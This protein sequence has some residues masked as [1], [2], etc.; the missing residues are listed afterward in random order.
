MATGHAMLPAGVADVLKAALDACDALGDHDALQPHMQSFVA[1][2]DQLLRIASRKKPKLPDRRTYLNAVAASNP[3]LRA[4][5]RAYDAMDEVLSVGWPTLS[6]AELMQ[7]K[8]QKKQHMAAQAK[9]AVPDYLQ[10]ALLAQQQ[11]QHAPALL[12]SVALPGTHME[13]R[14]GFTVAIGHAHNGL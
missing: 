5:A 4:R 6:N 9:R 7:R 13:C 1:A 14:Q 11:Q 3:N 10:T 2:A 8:R 12:R